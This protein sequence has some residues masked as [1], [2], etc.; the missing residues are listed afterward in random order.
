MLIKMS[1]ADRIVGRIIKDKKSKGAV[2]PP[3]MTRVNV[4][5]TQIN[6]Q[7]RQQV[8]PQVYLDRRGHR[9]GLQMNLS[10]RVTPRKTEYGYPMQRNYTTSVVGGKTVYNNPVAISRNATALKE[11]VRKQGY[12]I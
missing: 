12:R 9:Y 8:A 10:E 1:F 4:P 3:S 2:M 5:F 6:P 7:P 11:Y